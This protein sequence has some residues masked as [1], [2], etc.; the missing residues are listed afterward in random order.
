VAGGCEPGLDGFQEQLLVADSLS[1]L[2]VIRMGEF[3]SQVCES[4]IQ[5]LLQGFCLG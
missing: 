1:K 5:E 4:L 2:S 3:C